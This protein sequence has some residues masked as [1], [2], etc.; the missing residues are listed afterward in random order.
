[1]SKENKAWY[2]SWFD[3]PYYHTLYK[4]RDYAEAQMLIDNLSHYLNIEEG[5]KILDL[6]CGKG[7]HS[8]YLNKLGYDVTG[9]D[10]STNSIESAKEFESDTLHFHVHDMREPLKEKY[11]V[12][13]N[14]FTSFGYFP[15]PADNAR[16]LDAIHQSLTEY[17]LA[18]IDFMNVDKVIANL[19]PSEVK[20]VDGIDFHITR[21]YEDGFIIKNIVFD[22]DGEHHDFTEK[23]K[24]LRLE[25]FE[26]MMEEK[27][28]FLLDAFGDYKLRKF[29]KNESDRLIM[30]FK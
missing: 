10:L 3:T 11:D 27:G 7:R 29:Y 17:G 5:A 18:V 22:A 24:A 30:I 16:T 20:T 2:V 8:V 13:L 23:V 9:V 4:D 26:E 15:D 1:M 25:D 6:A 28:I 19:V 21:K 14:L 12:I